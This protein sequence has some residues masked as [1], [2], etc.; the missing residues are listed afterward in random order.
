M[1]VL[2][3]G[4]DGY[5][6]R[7]AAAELARRHE[8]IGLD[9]GLFFDETAFVPTIRR[10]IRDVRPADLEAIDAVVHLAALSNDPLGE[11]DPDLTTDINLSG[12][13]ALA[14][15]ARSQDVT[16][17]V[18]LSSCSVY[19]AGGSHAPL[20]DE[21][22]PTAP[23]TTYASA[24][25]HAEL[26]LRELASSEFA[27]VSLRSATAYGPSPRFRS[28]LVVNNL[29]ASALAHGVIHLKSTGTA[30]RPVVHVADIAKAVLVALEA[31][32]E[33]IRGATFN[34]G[35][36]DDN[37]PVREIA[38]RIAQSTSALVVLEPGAEPDERSYRVS[39]E[40]ARLLLGY[41]ATWSLAS[42]VTA[43]R[44]A[45]LRDY[46]DPG[47]LLSE[48]FVRLERLRRRMSTGEVA[49]DLRTAPVAL[50]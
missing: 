14:E 41:E 33:V 1:R 22:G 5:I 38:D 9:S 11:V 34:I 40:R 29:M 16:R 46:P 49:A 3:T 37:Y 18:F 31:P 26:R 32:Q 42:G 27:P 2:L 47:V 44:E 28:D 36:T 50:A 20:M 10:D 13:V 21:D 12:T 24:K 39:F 8:V 48:E 30:W 35:S 15:L 4:S 6:G 17:F 25:L 7:V 43:L 19:G 45:L 23:L